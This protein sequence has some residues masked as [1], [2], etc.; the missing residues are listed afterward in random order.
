MQQMKRT[1]ALDKVGHGLWAG[2]G[3]GGGGWRD[4]WQAVL[5]GRERASRGAV[6][7]AEKGR[8]DGCSGI[9]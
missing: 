6:R 1:N 8:G 9:E 4:G 5:F 7:R 3:R 2:V